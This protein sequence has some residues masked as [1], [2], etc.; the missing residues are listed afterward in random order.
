MAELA[1]AESSQPHQH[2]PFLRPYRL[3]EIPHVHQRLPHQPW[4]SKV[5]IATAEKWAWLAVWRPFPTCCSV[6]IHWGRGSFCIRAQAHCAGEKGT[7]WV[8]YASAGCR[9][10]PM[11]GG[12]ELGMPRGMGPLCPWA[13]L[14]TQTRGTHSSIAKLRFLLPAW[15]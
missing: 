9:I 6:S 14:P 13:F 7:A 3:K 12:D 1:A 5:P 11:C 15:R 4:C 2:E 8:G 10:P